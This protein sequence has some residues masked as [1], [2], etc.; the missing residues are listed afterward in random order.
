MCLLFWFV[1]FLTPP[2]RATT[3]MQLVFLLGMHISDVFSQMVCFLLAVQVVFLLVVHISDV[4]SQRVCV[5][6]AV[7]LVFLL[8]VHI[9][10]VF[11][12]RVCFLLAVQLVFL[13][14]VHISDTM[15]TPNPDGLKALWSA[16]VLHT[17]RVSGK[18]SG[19][20][21]AKVSGG[22]PA[23]VSGASPANFSGGSPA[24]FSGRSPANVSCA[25]RVLLMAILCYERA[26]KG[27][28]VLREGSKRQSCATGGLLKAILGLDLKP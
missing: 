26:F 15:S 8:V 7:Q 18:F 25:T 21:P 12:Q 9:S 17:W 10:D 13:L 16:K 3:S 23:K 6:L 24:N 19:G 14:V 27:N 1:F 5:L 4:F 28:P 22:S 20:S 11:S 2:L